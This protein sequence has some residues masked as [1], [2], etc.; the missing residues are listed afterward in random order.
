MGQESY[1]VKELEALKAKHPS[2]VTVEYFVDEEGSF[3][4]ETA[5]QKYIAEMDQRY[6]VILSGP[7][8]FISSLAG[9]K[10]WSNGRE[11]QGPLGGVLQHLGLKSSDVWKL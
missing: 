5:L 11:A 6:H 2:Q 10:V 3:I 7:D 1:I 8:G 4:T 9:P